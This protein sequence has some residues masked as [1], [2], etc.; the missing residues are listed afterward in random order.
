MSSGALLGLYNIVLKAFSCGKKVA[1]FRFRYL[2][3]I[4]HR[5]RMHDEY[6][7]LLLGDVQTH[8]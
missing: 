1:A 8:M 3:L 6:L 5:L 2:K 4:E 7:S